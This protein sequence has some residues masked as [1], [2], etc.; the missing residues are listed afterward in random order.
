MRLRYSIASIAALAIIVMSAHRAAAV[1][2]SIEYR[3]ATQIS[4]LSAADQNGAS[5]SITSL[6]GISYF[7]GD[8]FVAVADNSNK[9]F[10][11]EVAVLGDGSL[12]E[13]SILSGLSFDRAADHEGV[14]Y[15]GVVRGG[16]WVADESLP[17][18]AQYELTEGTQLQTLAVPTVFSQRRSGFGLESLAL[19]FDGQTLWTA[20]EEALT[21]DGGRSSPTETTVVRLLRYNRAGDSFAP[22]E[23]FAYVVDAW[24]GGDIA[25]TTAERGGL[26]ELVGLPDGRLLALERSL[27]NGSPLFENRIYLIDLTGADDVSSFASLDGATYMPVGKELL[28]SG[29]AAGTFGMNLEGLALGRRLGESTW[30]LV[31]VVDDGGS[32]DPFSANAL[33]LFELSGPSG[34]LSPGDVNLDGQIDRRDLALA[35]KAYGASSG[36]LWIDGDQSSDGQV[37][38][39]DLATLGRRIAVGSPTAVAI[40]V[41]EPSTFGMAIVTVGI[42]FVSGASKRGR[43]A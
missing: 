27:A 12:D 42:W 10:H 9:L 34:L 32:A 37:D 39:H 38:L 26:V 33:S 40:G 43:A 21:V 13:P 17:S 25:I 35:A 29:S 8:R 15:A 19:S 11:L 16:V 2:W 31:G 41:A 28:W 6:S 14:A 24:H 20:N 4:D 23:Q 22:A 1:D 30:S 7:G 3:G 18:V 5:L 36:A